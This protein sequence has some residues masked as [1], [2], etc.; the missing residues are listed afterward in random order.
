MGMESRL[1]VAKEWWGCGWLKQSRGEIFVVTAVL[2]PEVYTLWANVF[3]GFEIILQPCKVQPMG[4]TGETIKLS[5][6]V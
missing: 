4:E 2:R 5:S 6:K 1:V 3:P